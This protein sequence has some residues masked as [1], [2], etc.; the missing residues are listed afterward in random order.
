MRRL[1]WSAVALFLLAAPAWAHDLWA[2][3]QRF[4]VAPGEAAAVSV[5]IG[6]GAARETWSVPPERILLFRSVGPSGAVDRRSALRPGAAPMLLR[7]PT[8]GTH[9]LALQTNHAQSVLPA[10]RFNDYLREEGLTPAQQLRA[11]AG[12]SKAPGR[13]IYS[14]RVK[15]LVQVGPAGRPQPQVTR[16]LG[17]D[18]E[19]VPERNPY[20]PG[21]GS[22]LPVRV[23]FEGKPL[24]GALVKLTNLHN[25][26][27]PLAVARTDAQGRAAFKVPR[28]GAW[29]L[30]VVWTKPLQGDPRADFDTTFSSLAF[31]YPSGLAAR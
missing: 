22:A 4:W 31:G 16:P 25:D 13:E 3:P 29:M 1:S 12:K 20:D 18:L 21:P 9:V 5:Q 28:A 26:A 14:R 19:I 23:M 7:F 24:P 8:A 27:K 17:L 30:N 15:T 11:R 2:Q 6:H 10:V